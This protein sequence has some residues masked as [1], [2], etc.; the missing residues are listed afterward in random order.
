[1]PLLKDIPGLGALF[2]STKRS[3]DRSELVVLMRAR[4]LHSPEEAALVAEQEKSLLIGVQNA[5]RESQK[6]EEKR[7]KGAKT[8][9]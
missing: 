6:A 5:E 8:S 4:V 2:R 7:R 1:M 9:R 3:N